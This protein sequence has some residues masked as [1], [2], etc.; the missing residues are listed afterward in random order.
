MEKAKVENLNLIENLER[1]MIDEGHH[2]TKDH[3]FKILMN[4]FIKRSVSNGM[5]ILAVT[6]T[7]GGKM[8]EEQSIAKLQ[9]LRKDLH[10][11]IFSKVIVTS[12]DPSDFYCDP[13]TRIH[14]CAVYT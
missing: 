10:C 6:A 4:T 9:A 13:Y 5:R 2:T 1:F 8:D 11:D 14:Q 3:P 7:P 12:V